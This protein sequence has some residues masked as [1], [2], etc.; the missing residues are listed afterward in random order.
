MN[1]NNFERIFGD[2]PYTLHAL[3]PLIALSVRE[4]H[5]VWH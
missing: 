5:Q 1:F 4:A 2:F 3:Q